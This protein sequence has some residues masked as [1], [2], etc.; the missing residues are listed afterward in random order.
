MKIT[1]LPNGVVISTYNR[2]LKLN[3]FIIDRIASW[4]IRKPKA[5]NKDIIV[6]ILE[7][8][9]YVQSS[10]KGG[11]VYTKDF[12]YVVIDS[13]GVTIGTDVENRKNN[14]HRINGYKVTEFIIALKYFNRI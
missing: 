6:S 5:D 3:N 2:V 14:G 12:T 1:T 9:G 11:V 4:F 13:D 7:R 10:Y 8:N